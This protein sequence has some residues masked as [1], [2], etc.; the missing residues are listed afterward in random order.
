MQEWESIVSQE[1]DVGVVNESREVKRVSKESS[2]EIT[3]AAGEE[4]QKE[5]L[6]HVE[7]E[8]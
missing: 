8:I 2:Q 6:H 5:E 7:V 3:R 4:R 1:R